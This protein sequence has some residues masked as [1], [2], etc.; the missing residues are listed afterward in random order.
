[1]R[2]EAVKGAASRR[3]GGCIRRQIW[4][5]RGRLPI[6]ECARLPDGGYVSTGRQPRWR[7]AMYAGSRTPTSVI[8][9]VLA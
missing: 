3:R 4:S 6:S 9:T 5:N 7:H 2:P 1:M 8:A